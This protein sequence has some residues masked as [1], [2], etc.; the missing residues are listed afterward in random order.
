MRQ[1]KTLLLCSCAACIIATSNQSFAQEDEETEIITVTARKRTE[2]L[3]DVPIS[4]SAFTAEGLQDKL[5]N[6]IS[7]ISDFTPGFQQQQAFGRDG[8]R[9]VIRGASNILVAEGKVGFFLDGVPL[10]GDLSALNFAAFQQI[11]VIK[12]P[13]SALFGRGTLSGAINLVTRRPDDEWSGEIQA[14]Y[15]NFDTV[16]ASGVVSGPIIDGISA[17]ITG[18]IDR[19]GGDFENNED[20][21]RLNERETNAAS[22]FLYFDPTENFTGSIKALYQEVDDGHFAI[23]LQDSSFNNV[24]LDTRGYFDGVVEPRPL[25]EYG[26]NTDDILRPGL[27]RE[28]LQFLADFTYEFGDSGFSLSYLGGYTDQEEIT[29]VDQTYDETAVFFIGAPLPF[30]PFFG[31]SVCQFSIQNADCAMSAFHTTASSER[32]VFSHE[33]RLRSPDDAPLRGSIGYFHLNEDRMGTSDFLEATEF[34]LDSLADIQRIRNNSVFVSFEADVTEKLIFTGELRYSRD[35]IEREAQI[36]TASDFFSASDFAG[37][38]N[39]NPDQIVGDVDDNGDPVSRSATFEAWLPRITALYQITDTVNVYAQY[40]KGNAPG[41]FNPIDA[42]ITTIDE[43]KLSN[44]E[45]GFKGSFP[46][47]GLSFNTAAFFIRYKNQGL[48]QTFVTADGGLD[49]FVANI[50]VTET[51]GLELDFNLQL[52][53]YISLG[54]TVAYLD[55]EIDEGSITDQ[56][57]LLGGIDC[58]DEPGG[59]FDASQPNCPDGIDSIAGNTPPLVSDWQFTLSPRFNYPATADIDLFAGADVI[60]RSSFFAQVHNLA[61][62]GSALR[63]NLQA[64]LRIQDNIE[65]RF[66]AEN[67]TQNETPNGILRYVDFNAPNVPETGLDPRAFGITPALRRSYGATVLF[68]F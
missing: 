62:T 60:Y 65:V 67:V 7:E 64:G 25:E 39:A 38:T 42:P 5:I 16:R 36:Y 13:Q 30:P 37:F 57:I 14:T 34:G 31:Q 51:F 10:T 28:T 63:L 17:V 18:A 59:D 41:G 68:R 29:G 21:G 33:V 66:W 61:E 55:A 56:G 26:L 32:E 8:D 19:F 23:D 9:P 44:Y 27:Y 46:D 12:G 48:T 40:S 22:I 54:G 6:D 24:F 1:I 11:E 3:S 45:I 15:G 53:D 52:S 49:S 35:K 2:D 43:E 58:L 20:G 4:V 50:G 47:I